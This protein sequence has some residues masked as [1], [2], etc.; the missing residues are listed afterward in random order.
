MWLEVKSAFTVVAVIFIGIVLAGTIVIE[1]VFFTILLIFG[2]ALYV[3][4]DIIIGAKIVNNEVKPQ[5]DR[6]P[7]GYETCILIDLTRNVHIFNT[8]KGPEGKREFVFNGK[9]AT[10]INKGDYQVRLANGNSAFIGHESSDENLNLAEV[11]YASL[12][13]RKFETSDIRNIFAKVQEEKEDGS[14]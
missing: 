12:L 4:G 5:M 1:D 9:D 14:Q 7:Y 10:I 11:E 2:I 8:K 6:S 13:A 3:V